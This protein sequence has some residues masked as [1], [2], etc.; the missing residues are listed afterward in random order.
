MKND[1]LYEPPPLRGRG[2]FFPAW[3]RYPLWTA[4]GMLALYLCIRGFFGVMPVLERWLEAHPNFMP[5]R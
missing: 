5:M 3:V 2:H 4:L 1:R